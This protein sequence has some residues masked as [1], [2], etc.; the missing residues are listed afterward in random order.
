VLSPGERRAL[1]AHL[2][3][4]QAAASLRSQRASATRR[5]VARVDE[6]ARVGLHVPPAASVEAWV[7]ER[8][9]TAGRCLA[10]S[11]LRRGARLDDR[12]EVAQQV[13][14][15]GPDVAVSLVAAADLSGG[16][17]P[18]ASVALRARLSPPTAWGV[19]GTWRVEVGPTAF[20]Q[21]LSVHWP[22]APPSAGPFDPP[23]APG[24]R[25]GHAIA[26]LRAAFA[27][28]DGA[29]V[30]VQVAGVRAEAAG[31]TTTSPTS[32]R[33]RDRLATDPP[34]ADGWSR[35][36]HASQAHS[37]LLLARLDATLARIEVLRL[38]GVLAPTPP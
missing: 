32:S 9:P 21:D 30:R 37:R 17:P 5:L 38:C 10:V 31:G 29:D 3:L 16:A 27:D 11:P 15:S 26:T 28:V 18:A 2:D 22:A 12:I 7:A 34:G 14:E 35:R 25:D 36:A 1:E 6:A 4:V 33:G 8:V 23:T 20:A 24:R 19:T 13:A